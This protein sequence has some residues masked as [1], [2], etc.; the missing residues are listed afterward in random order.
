MQECSGGGG[1][2]V[3]EVLR[4]H[5]QAVGHRDMKLHCWCGWEGARADNGFIAHQA[6]AI[7]DAGYRKPEV[8]VE[9]GTVHEANGAFYNT[10]RSRENAQAFVDSMAE[11]DHAM[12]VVTREHVPAVYGDWKPAA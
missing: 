3:M 10:H 9:W 6:G 5:Q 2:T 12:I 8:I 1:M 11:V 7:L 4:K